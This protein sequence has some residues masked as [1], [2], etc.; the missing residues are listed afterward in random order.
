MIADKGENPSNPSTPQAIL[1]TFFRGLEITG[2]FAESR[3]PS[4]PAAILKR[5]LVVDYSQTG[6][7]SGDCCPTARCARA[8][9]SCIGKPWFRS[10]PSLALA[11]RGLCR[12]DAGMRATRCAAAPAAV[13]CRRCRFRFDHPV[14]SGLVFLPALPITAFLHSAEGKRL[15]RGKPVVTWSPA[16][17]CGCRPETMSRLDRRSG[18][19]QC[20]HIALTDSGHPLPPSSPRRAGC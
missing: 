5:V 12:R 14:L 16:A 3:S 20:D 19:T 18:G 8:A 17:I 11:H 4:L 6:Q 7:L 1:I 15:I 13:D 10:S 9:M 2:A